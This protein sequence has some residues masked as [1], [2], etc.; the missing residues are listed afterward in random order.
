MSYLLQVINQLTYF[1]ISHV[2]I[3]IFGLSICGVFILAVALA[4][5]QMTK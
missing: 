1:L 3:N 4:S 5:G 2:H